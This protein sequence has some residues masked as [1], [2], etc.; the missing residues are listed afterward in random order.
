MATVFEG[1]LSAELRQRDP[2]HTGNAAW[3][4]YN[5]P[6]YARRVARPAGGRCPLPVSPATA[7]C[8]TSRWRATWPRSWRSSDCCSCASDSPSRRAVALATAFLP[9]LVDHS[10]YPLTDSWGLALE[11]SAFAAALLVLDRGRRWLV[12]WAAVILLLAFTRD[13][14]WIPVLAVGWVAWRQ[15]SRDALW[16]FGTGLAAALPAA[17]RLPG[18]RS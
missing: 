3:V 1:P 6:F 13:S 11:T 17:A 2:H 15:R 4:A 16:L 12:A 9:P 18:A 10:S 7:R 14:T 5:E 8:S